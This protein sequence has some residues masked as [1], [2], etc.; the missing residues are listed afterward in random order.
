MTYA[1]NVDNPTMA[2]TL[3]KEGCWQVKKWGDRPKKAGTG[4]WIRHIATRHEA[5]AEAWAADEVR[6]VSTG[7]TCLK[8]R[9]WL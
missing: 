2:A 6:H 3:H 5:E 9:D 4:H 7:C 1:V 8:R